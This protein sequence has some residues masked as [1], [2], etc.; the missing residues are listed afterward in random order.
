MV[1][2][3]TTAVLTCIRC[4]ENVPAVL[5]R[6]NDGKYDLPYDCIQISLVDKTRATDI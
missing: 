6:V 3:K 1:S 2:R 5:G 4:A